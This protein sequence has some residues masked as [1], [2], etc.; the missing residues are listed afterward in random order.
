MAGCTA[1]PPVLRL[2]SGAIARPVD[3]IV[4]YADARLSVMTLDEKIESMLMVH[5]PGLDVSALA[6][7]ASENHV[8]GLI[9]MGDNVPDPAADLASMTSGM[10]ADPGLPLLLGID[11]E[12][13]IVR[14]IDTDTAASA[15]ELRFLDPDA[16]R[17]AFATRGALLQSLGVSINFG[18]VADVTGDPD[19]FIYERSL[20]STAADAAARVAAAVEGER[21]TVLSTL[22]HFPGHG[23][24]PGDSHSSIPTTQISLDEWRVDHEPPFAA[25]ID[26]GAEVV[27][28]GHLQFDA[29]DP[30][31]ASLSPM[32]HDLLRTELGFEGLII[33]DDMSMLQN[34]GRDDLVDPYQN[35]VRA[36][37]AGN[38]MLL[39]VG[40]VDVPGVV[41]A[42]RDAV[43]AGTIDEALIDDA[44]W[45]IL[46][47][48]RVE[49]GQTGPFVH[50]FEQC[51][52]IIE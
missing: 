39:Y 45:R 51:Q 25:G 50:C 30:Q 16:S 12:G 10:S 15:E 8:G 3:P 5:V 46:A 1:P 24:S 28:F 13:G 31:P 35:A 34:S 22:K 4:Q 17:D 7:F 26:A 21:G 44:A 52:S 29:V 33:T 32:W 38:T 37:A 40:P 27:M 42:V 14:R 11:Q 23:V 48:R 6:A 18:I 2:A 36:V 9:L 19:S 47:A 43:Q 20:G 49:S 41:A